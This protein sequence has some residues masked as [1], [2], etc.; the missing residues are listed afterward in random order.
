MYSGTITRRMDQVLSG[1]E[2]EFP[3]PPPGGREKLC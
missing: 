2:T 1:L 3:S